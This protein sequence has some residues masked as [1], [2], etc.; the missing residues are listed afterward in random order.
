[1]PTGYTTHIE[2]GDITIGK[3]FLMLC[4]R[5]FEPCIEMKDKSL[6]TP[7]PKKFDECNYYFDKLKTAKLELQKYESMT[8]EEAKTESESEYIKRQNDA[9]EEISK[10]KLIRERYMKILHEIEKWVPPTKDHN[11]LKKFA[12]QQIKMSLPNDEDDE[13]WNSKLAIP[14]SSVKKWLKDNIDI[15]LKDIEYYS[16]QMRKEKEKIQSRNNWIKD[17]RESLN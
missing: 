16:K 5:A 7:I 10:N 14:M 15:C 12:I 8:Y 17:L 9:S 6:D 2:N 3:D 13:Y 11:E 1:M 4:A